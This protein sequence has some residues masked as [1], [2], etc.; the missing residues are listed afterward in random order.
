MIIM[1]TFH[2]FYF[3]YPS[4]TLAKTCFCQDGLN[5]IKL[6]LKPLLAETCQP[7]SSEHPSLSS[8]LCLYINILPVLLYGADMYVV[9]DCH[10]QLMSRCLWSIVSATH[11]PHMLH[12]THLKPDGPKVNQSA[13]SHQYHPRSTP[14]TEPRLHVWSCLGTSSLHL[15]TRG[16]ATSELSNQS[17]LWT[18]EGNLNT[19][20]ISLCSAW[21]ITVKVSE[22]PGAGNPH[23]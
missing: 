19:Q 2:F 1:N 7:W 21:H 18:M 16:L 8:K 17:C 10:C 3:C 12:S 9:D 4:N 11:P 6:Q 15:S 13:Q 5:Q 22:T 20:N 23:F 14:W